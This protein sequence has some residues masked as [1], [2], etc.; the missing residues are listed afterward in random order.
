MAGDDI[1]PGDVA[2]HVAINFSD[3]FPVVATACGELGPSADRWRFVTCR[4]CL[5]V[6][7]RDPRIER[8]RR[9]L[10]LPPRDA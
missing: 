5:V 2:A 4:A 9:A 1:D 6:A 7:P 3:R 8:R 10:G